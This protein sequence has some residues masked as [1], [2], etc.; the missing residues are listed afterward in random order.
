[1]ER[2]A[3]LTQNIV[4]FDKINAQQTPPKKTKQNK[5]QR[6]TTSESTRSRKIEQKL[7]SPD[8]NKDQF[9]K[10]GTIESKAYKDLVGLL[11][12]ADRV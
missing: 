6:P 2:N 11:I 4:R 9:I 7:L 8:C 10:N 5:L 3:S 12:K 1:M